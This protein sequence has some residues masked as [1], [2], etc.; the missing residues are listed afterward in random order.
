MR[1]RTGLIAGVVVLLAGL[2]AIAG[3]R[4]WHGRAP[5]PPEALGTRTTLQLAD[6]ATAAA[7]LRPV[8]VEVSGKDDQILLGTV[9]WTVPPSAPAGNSF[10]LVLLDRRSM[11]MPGFVSVTSP[12]PESVGSGSDD[13]LDVAAG[14]YDWLAGAGTREIDGAFRA[15]ATSSRPDRTPRR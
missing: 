8:N 15:R 1:G 6:R 11:A 5:Y 3:W 9:S 2:G 7:A 4:W 10:R 14:R 13:T 12:R